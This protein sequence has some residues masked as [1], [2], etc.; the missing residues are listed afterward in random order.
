MLNYETAGILS[1]VKKLIKYER[2][3]HKCY[4]VY[5][6]PIIMAVMSARS[7]TIGKGMRNCTAMVPIR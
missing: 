3:I 4:M 7:V 1:G 5:P 2:R 6:E